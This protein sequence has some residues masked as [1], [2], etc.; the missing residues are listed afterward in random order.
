MAKHAKRSAWWWQGAGAPELGPQGSSHQLPLLCDVGGLGFDG[1]FR[2]LRARSVADLRGHGGVLQ[3]A[4]RGVV[5]GGGRADVDAEQDGTPTVQ[6]VPEDV[7]DLRQAMP[8]SLGT[9][10]RLESWLHFGDE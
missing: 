8:I 7:R 5:V 1:A 3:H 9:C 6:Q 2:G 10:A 4:G